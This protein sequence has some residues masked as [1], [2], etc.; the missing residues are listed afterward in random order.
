[1]PRR[2]EGDALAIVVVSILVCLLIAAI[3]LGPFIFTP[4]VAW[5]NT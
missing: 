2:T 3:A 4:L 1:M 5:L